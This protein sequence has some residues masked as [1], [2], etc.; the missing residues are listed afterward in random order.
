MLRGCRAGS[1]C[2]RGVPIEHRLPSRWS[3]PEVGGQRSATKNASRNTKSRW[4]RVHRPGLCRCQ[5]PRM[6]V[7]C[8]FPP[9]LVRAGSVAPKEKTCLGFLPPKAKLSSP[10]HAS[11]GHRQGADTSS[12]SAASIMG[13]SMRHLMTVNGAAVVVMLLSAAMYTRC[14]CI[15]T[16]PHEACLRATPPRLEVQCLAIA[17]TRADGPVGP[18]VWVLATA[19]PP[20]LLAER[21]RLP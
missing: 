6:C 4:L 12:Y 20:L 16:K 9:S 13:I 14:G 3:A 18:H 19:W 10:P 5:R 21:R 15:A 17:E 2:S 11:A 1:F 8:V 7:C